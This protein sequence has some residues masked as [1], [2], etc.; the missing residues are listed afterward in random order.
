MTGSVSLAPTNVR[1]DADRLHPLCRTESDRD[2]AYLIR[3][4]LR[5]SAQRERGPQLADFIGGSQSGEARICSVR[6][7]SS[8]GLAASDRLHTSP[9]RIRADSW[10]CPAAAAIVARSTRGT[11]RKPYPRCLAGGSSDRT[12]QL[13]DSPPPVQSAPRRL[14]TPTSSSRWGQPRQNPR[15]RRLG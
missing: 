10:R 4:L 9:R 3:T 6:S 7:D 15:R 13:W 12:V 11:G 8:S 5:F 14:V 2:L 1:H